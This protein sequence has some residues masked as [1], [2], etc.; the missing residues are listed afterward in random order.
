[1]EVYVAPGKGSLAAPLTRTSLL[2]LMQQH[3]LHVTPAGQ[4]QPLPS[5]K[6]LWTLESPGS[7]LRIAFQEDQGRL[8]FATIEQSMFN[9]TD[10]ADR[11]CA[12]LESAGWHVDSEYVG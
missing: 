10:L 6:T 3:G 12:A 2:S 7:E 5:G 11:I 4:G 9:E 1:M 8:V